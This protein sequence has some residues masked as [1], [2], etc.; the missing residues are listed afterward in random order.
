MSSR[1]YFLFF[2]DFAHDPFKAKKLMHA[3]KNRVSTGYSAG[4]KARNRRYLVFKLV[5]NP[6]YYSTPN[7][8][9]PPKQATQ[10]P[11][12]KRL[13]VT[14]STAASIPRRVNPDGSRDSVKLDQK[15]ETLNTLQTRASTYYQ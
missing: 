10:K 15:Q 1:F 3:Q 5:H 7:N 6:Q 2:L 8:T 12:H 13:F 4:T 14:K 9:Y 11:T